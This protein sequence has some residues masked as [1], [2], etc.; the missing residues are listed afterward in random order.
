[1]QDI[2]DYERKKVL[3]F[4]VMEITKKKYNAKSVQP[5]NQ[6][7]RYQCNDIS[8]CERKKLLEEF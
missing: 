5:Y 7:C 8:E 2:S 4:R 3:G 6:T 1:M